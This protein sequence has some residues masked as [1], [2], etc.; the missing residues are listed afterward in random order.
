MCVPRLVVEKMGI[1][2]YTVFA[3]AAGGER[4]PRCL[5]KVFTIFVYAMERIDLGPMMED[6]FEL[7]ACYWPIEYQP[8]SLSFIV[9]V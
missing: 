4:D 2:F 3:N 5:L 7:V 1:Q 9:I 8:V 6:V